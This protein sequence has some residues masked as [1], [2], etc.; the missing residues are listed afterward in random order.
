MSSLWSSVPWKDAGPAW[1]KHRVPYTQG[2]TYLHTLDVWAPKDSSSTTPGTD[3][4][5]DS[6]APWVVYIHGG[7]WRD[8]LVDSSSFEATAIKLLGSTDVKIAGV[9]SINYPL[10]VHRNH[11]TQPAPPKDPSQPLD[12]A[13]QATHPDHILAVLSGIEYLQQEVGILQ[14]YILS[15][16]SCGATLTF[17]VVMSSDRWAKSRGTAPKV[18]K[19]KV[20]VGLNGL[21]DLK[22]FIDSPPES[23]AALQAAYKEFT[24][25]AFGED[26]SVWKTVCP[27]D[28]S[29]WSAE[30]PEG[31]TVVVVQS[32]KDGLVPY[33][34]TV[35]MKEKLAK[36]SKLDVVEMDAGG[37]HNDLWGKGDELVG[38]MAEVVSKYA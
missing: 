35:L 4:V 38:I 25:G 34:Q 29:D 14:N 18:Q 19:P 5:P 3:Y 12:E 9:V 16:H 28:V 33:S 23:H 30:W 36:H 11:P 31:K 13:R 20:I 7:A 32:K 10:S 24:E 1:Y 2:G 17:Q 8:P 26:P 27:T 6:K 37:D 21:Y 22:H 15:G